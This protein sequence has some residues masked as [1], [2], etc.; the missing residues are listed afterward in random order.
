MSNN[1]T[2]PIIVALS[3]DD[4]VGS[5]IE[6]LDELITNGIDV[7]LQTDRGFFERFLIQSRSEV[8]DQT[9]GDGATFNLEFQKIRVAETQEVDAPS[10]RI[11]RARSRAT[12]GRQSTQATGDTSTVSRSTTTADDPTTRRSALLQAGTALRTSLGL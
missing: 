12:R 8:R 9:T 7:D 3:D 5:V 4:R 1:P 6:Q 11:E 2:N 10:P